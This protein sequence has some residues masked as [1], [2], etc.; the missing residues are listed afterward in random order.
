M[1]ATLYLIAL[2]LGAAATQAADRAGAYLN[3]P[4]DWFHSDEGKAVVKNII[5]WQTPEG[6]WPKN[7]ATT[8]PPKSAAQKGTFDNGATTDEL[9][10]L[11]RSL[12]ATK[13][14]ASKEAFYKGLDHI[15]SAQYPNA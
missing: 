15:L 6:S 4:A 2:L 13:D 8:V 1:R 7:T 11:A 14:T 5:A 12:S 9:R 10:L 3:K